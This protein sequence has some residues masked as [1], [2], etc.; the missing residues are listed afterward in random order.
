MPREITRGETPEWRYGEPVVERLHVLVQ[1]GYRAQ[2]GDV[3]YVAIDLAHPKAPQI[4]LSC[5]GI[6]EE[7]RHPRLQ[8]EGDTI[9]IAADDQEGFRAFLLDRPRLSPWQQIKLVPVAELVSNAWAM[10][11]AILVLAGVGWLLDHAAQ[12]PRK[13][14]IG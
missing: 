1:A 2:L 6:I 13:P 14:V 3:G 12:F 9:W 8:A 5:D 11:V 7:R 10:L 4:T